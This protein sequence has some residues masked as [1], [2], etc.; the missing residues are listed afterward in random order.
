MSIH[1]GVWP[2]R[3]GAR[4]TISSHSTSISLRHKQYH[5]RGKQMQ[6]IKKQ[7]ERER[8]Q[9][10]ELIDQ[11]RAIG[12]AALVAALLHTKKRKTSQP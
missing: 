5:L 3:N 11:Y 8:Q 10:V 7:S 9:Y 2:G 6:Q 1:E 12:P 4:V